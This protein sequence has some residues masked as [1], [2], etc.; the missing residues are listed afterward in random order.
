MISVF[1]P[2]GGYDH[3]KKTISELK[4]SE[5]VKKVTLLVTDDNI[6][7]ID[8][9]DI[10]R[11]N[12]INSSS[13]INAIAETTENDFT[14]FITQDN[15]YSFSQFAIE[16]FYEVSN[17]TNS[18]LVYSDYYEIK[19][20]EKHLHPLIDYQVGSLRDDFNFGYVMLFKSSLLKSYSLKKKEHQYAG[21]YSLRL[22]ISVENEIIRIPEALYTASEPDMRKS[23][24]KQFDYVD[25]KNRDVQ[26]DMELACTEHLKK[27]G[28]YLNPDFNEVNLQGK[29]FEYEASVIIP[30]KNRVNTISDAI[31]SVLSHVT[32]I[33]QCKMKTADWVQNADCFSSDTRQHVI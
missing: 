26:I 19:N 14:M 9:C 5:L 30:V 4:S 10:L 11:V 33:G 3:T 17:S 8:G 32:P 28:A 2:Y 15:E 16:R 18:G 31:K 22:F 25:P 20:N 29:E 6:T 13:T 23:G 27:I 1:L 12:N 24:A 21:I 7:K